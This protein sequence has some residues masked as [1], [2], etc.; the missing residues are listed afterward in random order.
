M[1]TYMVRALPALSEA[2]RIRGQQARRGELRHRPEGARDRGGGEN[3]N[4]SAGGQQGAAILGGEP[5]RCREPCL[6]RF[7]TRPRFVPGGHVIPQGPVKTAP[8]CPRYRLR[9]ARRLR[10]GAAP[11][12]ALAAPARGQRRGG[13]CRAGR[14][15]DAQIPDQNPGHVPVHAADVGVH[16]RPRAPLRRSRR[17]AAPA[18]DPLPDPRRSGDR[19]R[20]P[21]EH[22]AAGDLRPRRRVGQPARPGAQHRPLGLVL[23]AAPLARLHHRHRPEAVRP[24]G[25]ADGRRLRPRVR[26]LHRRSDGAA[27]VGGRQRLHRRRQGPAADARRRRGDV[28]AAPGRACTTRSTA[29]R[30]RR[31]RRCTSGRRCWRRSCSASRTPRPERSAG[32]TPECS[33]SRSS[34]SASTTSST[35]SPASGW[36]RPSASA[37]RSPNRS[38]WRSARGVQQLERDRQL[39]G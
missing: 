7:Y 39:V 15:G 12:Q 32:P 21:A 33:A 29:I 5:G 22:A 17:V 37:S 35:C 10:G 9:R 23:R 6:R 19:R 11:A 27:L 28:R 4:S 31:C 13:G 3:R 30:G 26:D 20:S 36:S 34:T 8:L 16:D 38:R 1:I 2:V 25:A 14:P 24:G 18:Q